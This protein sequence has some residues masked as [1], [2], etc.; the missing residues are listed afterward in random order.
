M[1][2]ILG[3]DELWPTCIVIVEGK[4]SLEQHIQMIKIWDDWLGKKEAFHILRYYHDAHSLEQTPGVAKATKSWLRAGAQDKI[5]EYI[6][7]MQIVV[8]LESYDNVKQL[9]VERVFSVSGGIYASLD[10]AIKMIYTHDPSPSHLPEDVLSLIAS[11]F[12]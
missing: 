3:I 7:S 12:T 11:E 5:K 8:P 1:S 10:E 9:S 6:S 2:R 4:Q